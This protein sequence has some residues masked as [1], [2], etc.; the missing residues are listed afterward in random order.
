MKIFNY[1]RALNGN[2]SWWGS[3]LFFILT[4]IIYINNAIASHI[5]FKNFSEE[6]KFQYFHNKTVYGFQSETQDLPQY[7]FIW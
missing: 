7:H 6:W 1:K 2:E 3:T 4:K 5:G